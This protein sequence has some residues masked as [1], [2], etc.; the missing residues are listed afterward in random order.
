MAGVVFLLTNIVL[1]KPLEVSPPLEFKTE[2][3]FV[4]K[5]W[6]ALELGTEAQFG[7]ETGSMAPA[8]FKIFMCILLQNIV[9]CHFVGKTGKQG[10]HTNHNKL[11]RQVGRQSWTASYQS[12]AFGH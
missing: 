1:G 9:I 12:Y 11:A 4:W 10:G 7:L 8:S 6:Q 5:T 2:L 3:Y